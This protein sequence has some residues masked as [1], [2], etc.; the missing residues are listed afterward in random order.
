MSADDLIQWR[1]AFLKAQAKRAIQ[2]N[3]IFQK[4]GRND[5]C[6]CGSGL[7]YKKCCMHVHETALAGMDPEAVQKR[8]QHEQEKGRRDKQVKKGYALLTRGDYLGAHKHA[9]GCL[10][11][12]PE[13]DRFHD[14]LATAALYLDQF[15]EA[16]QVSESRW[17]AAER[18]KALF[19]AHGR[20]TYDDP[21][22]AP[23]HA[24][25]PQAWLEKYW[26]A[27]KAR[28]YTEA[29][30]KTPDQW[31]LRQVKA[32]QNADNLERFPQRREEG[33]QVRQEAL[34][35]VTQALKDIGPEALPYLLPLSIRYS[36]TGLL[37]PEILCHWGDDAS[38]RALVDIAL[39]HYPFLSESCLKALEELGDRSLPH[40]MIAFEQDPKFV[41]LK[42]GLISVAGHIA[43]PEAMEWITSL[44][45]HPDAAIVNWAGGILGKAGYVQA[46]A[47]L[48]ETNRRIGGEPRMQEA[49][50]TLRQL[51]K[52][53]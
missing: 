4:V 1:D 22:V 6:P 48:E 16:I 17:K 9:R 14:I 15:E 44:L 7:K 34:A 37:L 42:T 38:I 27:I 24:Y 5:P 51:S 23:G 32:L 2:E 18:E 25:A 28:D 53:E 31:I 29:Y 33:L 10:E 13:D 39:F 45:D 49:I 36:W 12:Y 52:Q 46:L 11:R 47:K 26:V 50:D 40:I 3:V 8:R 43:T 20:H 19:L 41:P 35:N 30:P 21:S